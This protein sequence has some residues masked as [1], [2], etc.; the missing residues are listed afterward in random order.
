[1]VQEGNSVFD[2]RND[3]NAIIETSTN[4]LII[5]CKNTK[6]PNSITCI[7]DYAFVGV[8]SLHT[9]EIPN[10]VISINTRAFME[11]TG[12]T[13]F[14]IPNSVT[15]IGEAAFENCTSLEDVSLPNSLTTIDDYVFKGCTSLTSIVIPNSV[16]NMGG[17]MFASCENLT[18]VI[19]PE[20][21]TSIGTYFF[22]KCSNL[23]SVEI[24]NNVTSLGYCAFYKCT[25]LQSIRIPS[26]VESIGNYA[27]EKCENLT[28]VTSERVEPAAIDERVFTNS[29]NATLY[30]PEESVEA[31]S[32]ATGWK[33]FKEIKAIKVENEYEIIYDDCDNGILIVAIDGDEIESGTLAKE[34]SILTVVAIAFTDYEIGSL[35]LNGNRINNNSSFPVDGPMHVSAKFVPIGFNEMAYAVYD[36][37]TLTFY[38]DGN[39]AS[40]TGEVYTDLV[41]KKASDG[42]G[43]HRESIKKVVFNSSFA[44]ARPTTTANWFNGCTALTTI[45]GIKHLNTSD[46]TSMYAMFNGCSALKS[47]DV[48]KFNT[49]KVKSMSYLFN[50]CKALT[51]LDLKNFNTSSVT[52]MSYMFNSCAAIQTIEVGTGWTT[53]NVTNSTRM[54]SACRKIMG[55]D[56]SR[57]NDNVT[58]KAAAH[59]GERGYLTGSK[60]AYCVY[61]DGVLTFYYDNKWSKRTGDVYTYL[62]RS[63][64]GDLWGVHKAD[65][66]KVVFTSDFAD[67]H[68]G[69]LFHWF[70]GFKALTTIS[71]IQNL[72]TSD[73]MV[74]SCMFN[75][76]KALT[77]L[78][79]SHFDTGKVYYS[80]YMFNSCSNLKTIYV[81]DGWTNSKMNSSG[82]MFYGCKALVG[83]TGTKYNANY[84]DKTRAYAGKGGYLTYKNANV[85]EFNN[86]DFDTTA[87]EDIQTS[88]TGDV[89]TLQGILVGKDVELKTLPK[90]IYIINGKKVMIK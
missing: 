18:S 13:S 39:S 47:I 19:L 31:Y 62:I 32:S 52:N 24:P 59:T 61:E 74:M 65:V 4:T 87:I 51:S 73:V 3:C 70:N 6:I 79:L 83:G 89:Y 48:S 10:S 67:T 46:V 54:L 35:T 21:L 23:Q 26:G 84:I 30:V 41:R 49:A 28:C 78:N 36:N 38:N 45:S 50:N 42:W 82:H 16:I 20:Q 37:G 12:L 29:P 43:A 53:A 17:H 8:E 60:R 77:S 86:E 44:N 57:Y 2:S 34:N 71:S 15:H 9:L 25:N 33:E 80:G 22:Y 72:N 68:P 40:R 58:D 27:F 14:V 88:T 5:G 11:C 56:A 90:G 69:S 76:C 1:M 75:G 85:K 66:T 64:S 81:G 7:G 63:K 55:S